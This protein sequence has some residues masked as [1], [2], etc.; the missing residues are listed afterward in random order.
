MVG[1]DPRFFFPS[2]SVIASR[3][4]TGTSSRFGVIAYSSW[5]VKEFSGVELGG[6]EVEF[7]WVSDPG[8]GARTA[9]GEISLVEK[10]VGGDGKCGA[11]G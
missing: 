8:L 6:D 10:E 4:L 5:K 1:L 11:V 2:S 3:L 9:V 7:S